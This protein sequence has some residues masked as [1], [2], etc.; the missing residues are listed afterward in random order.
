MDSRCFVG[1]LLGTLETFLGVSSPGRGYE[2]RSHIAPRRESLLDDLRLRMNIRR[3]SGSA[4][5]VITC[6]EEDVDY[7]YGCGTLIT[8]ELRL[9][10]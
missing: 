1:G 3:C 5:N 2:T 8:W 9:G 6:T 4:R 7:E 10:V